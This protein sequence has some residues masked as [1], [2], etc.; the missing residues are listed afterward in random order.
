M[1][2]WHASVVGFQGL[3]NFPSAT[4]VVLGRASARYSG[5][6]GDVIVGWGGVWP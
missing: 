2:Q 6:L 5:T 4:R 1:L 3:G